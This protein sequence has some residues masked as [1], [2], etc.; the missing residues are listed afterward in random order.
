MASS[1]YTGATW[2]RYTIYFKSLGLIISKWQMVDKLLQKLSVKKT[3]AILYSL[4]PRVRNCLRQFIRLSFIF[5][6]FSI[7][8][9]A[10]VLDSVFRLRLFIKKFVLRYFEVF[11]ASIT[12]YWRNVYNFIPSGRTSLVPAGLFIQQLRDNRNMISPAPTSLLISTRFEKGLVFQMFWGKG[13]TNFKMR[14]MRNILVK[15]RNL[16]FQGN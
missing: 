15:F 6:R 7:A 4:Q 10:I 11:S 12:C 13:D 16:F 2:L 5:W 3:L 9:H 8:R 1:Y 14:L